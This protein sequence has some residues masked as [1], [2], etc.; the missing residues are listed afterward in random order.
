M[1]V[2]EKSADHYSLRDADLELSFRHVGDR[3][4]HCVS[5]RHDG[6]WRPLLTSEEGSPADDV[7]PSPPFQDLRFEQLAERVCEFQLLGQSGKGVYSGAVR[8]DGGSGTIDFDLCARGRSKETRLCTASRYVLAAED[9][10]PQV[11]QDGGLLAL[12]VCGGRSVEI[13]AVPI[14]DCPRTECRLMT[15]DNVRRIDAGCFESTDLPGKV[16]SVRWRY[17]MNMAGRGNQ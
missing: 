11:Q 14:K 16:L 7:P 3:W 17:R 4:Q 10:L 13:E 12:F 5:V 6:Q 9:L 1:I 8:F 2:L 15:V